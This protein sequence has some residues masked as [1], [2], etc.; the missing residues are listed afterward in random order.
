MENELILESSL[1]DAVIGAT[2]FYP[3]SGMDLF[4]PVEIFSS[5]IDDFW[6][7]DR[8]Y[9]APGHPDT[10]GSRYDAPAD[11]QPPVLKGKSDYEFIEK[12]IEGPPSWDWNNSY[13]EPCLVTEKYL[14]RPTERH[15]TVRR[16]RGYG[17][18][19][20]RNEKDISPLGVFFYRGDSMGEGGSG[21]IWFTEEHLTEI[22]DRLME[23]GLIVTDSCGS[24]YR[25]VKGNWGC[26]DLPDSMP[27]EEI[28][29]A[30]KTRSFSQVRRRFNCVG[31]VGYW[32][33]PT[34]V[35]QVLRESGPPGDAIHLSLKGKSKL[36]DDSL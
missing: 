12:T 16:R 7:V 5:H 23:G 3:C 29:E 32:K 30:A 2:L 20:F 28:L 21:N 36:G 27:P 25:G 15:I 4:T 19:A 18:S 22:C 9:F 6:F 1:L 10:R 24:I 11:E 34:L 35:W 31:Y 13:I 17:Y 33:G 26:F 8:G 14:H